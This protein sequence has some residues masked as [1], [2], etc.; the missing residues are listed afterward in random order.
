[1]PQGLYGKA[2]VYLRDREEKPQIKNKHS[3]QDVRLR[4]L[5]PQENII[6]ETSIS[7]VIIDNA[8]D[9]DNSAITV[10][11][12][13]GTWKIEVSLFSGISYDKGVL[14]YSREGPWI[15]SQDSI[16]LKADEPQINFYL[17]CLSSECLNK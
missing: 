1:M 13:E 16:Y 5:D 3:W 10:A 14:T 11:L 15:K 9:F 17:H 8:I 4:V 6:T 7:K 12:P 2:K